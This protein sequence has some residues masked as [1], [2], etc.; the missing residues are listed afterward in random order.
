MCVLP[1]GLVLNNAQTTA[2]KMPSI[3]TASIPVTS[4]PNEYASPFGN[5]DIVPLYSSVPLKSPVVGCLPCVVCG[6]SPTRFQ[7]ISNE[8]G[9]GAGAGGG[10]GGGGGRGG[11]GGDGGGGGVIITPTPTP[12]PPEPPSTTVTFTLMGDCKINFTTPPV[13]FDLPPEAVVNSSSDLVT[14]LNDNDQTG[15]ISCS[16]GWSLTAPFNEGS[17]PEYVYSKATLNGYTAYTICYNTFGPPGSGYDD[18]CAGCV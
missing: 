7:I 18:G 5:D 12:T 15:G 3:Q 13:P 1:G 8:S 14:V 9:I 11:G 4:F 10:G 6:S 16:G 17:C 2:L